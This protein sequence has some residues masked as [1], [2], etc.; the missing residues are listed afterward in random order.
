LKWI[1]ARFVPFTMVNAV[2][3][4]NGELFSSHSMKHSK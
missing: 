2:A 1:C 4:V 3:I